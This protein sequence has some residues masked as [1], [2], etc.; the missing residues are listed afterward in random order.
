MTELTFPFAVMLIITG[1]IAGVANAVAG[2]G[3][4]FT[5]PAL[6]ASGLPPVV[7]NASNSVAVWPGHVLALVGYRKEL[8]QYS[9][10]IAGSI[11]IGF[12]GGIAG[13]VLLASLGN[14]EFSKLIPILILLA[15]LLFAFGGKIND[16]LKA[17]A[18]SAEFARPK[19]VTRFLEL[20]FAI[21]GGF[22]GAGLGVMLMAGLQML[23]VNDPHAN[24]ALKNLLA[25]VINT[26][27]VVVLAAAGLVAWPHTALAFAGAICGGLVGGHLARHIPAHVLRRIVIALGTALTVYYFHK[28]YA[29]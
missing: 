7:A 11:V 22:F 24:N 29:V 20:L 21:Y 15:T 19:P 6:L 3:T 8:R 2:G 27:S 26:V 1:A 13:A 5:F 23:G 10:A 28:Y 12:M 25:A 4:F 9:H 16:W 14:Q 17:R 18:V